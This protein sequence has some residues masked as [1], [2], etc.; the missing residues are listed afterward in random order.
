V[1]SIVRLRRLRLVQIVR[2]T[3]VKR[4]CVADIDDLVA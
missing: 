4:V 2:G 1:G 3:R